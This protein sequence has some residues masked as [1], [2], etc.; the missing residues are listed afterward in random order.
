MKI[1]ASPKGAI[2]DRVKGE[3]IESRSDEHFF[4]TDLIE[5]KIQAHYKRNKI[6]PREE[7]AI[8][9]EASIP[10]IGERTINAFAKTT[11]HYLDRNEVCISFRIVLTY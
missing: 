4:V 2:K 3:E 11:Y 9:F 5:K 8:I 10:K 1:K 6:L 7:D